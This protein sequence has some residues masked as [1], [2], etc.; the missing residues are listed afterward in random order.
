[1][2]FALLIHGITKI[3]ITAVTQTLFGIDIHTAANLLRKLGREI[4]SH[5]FQ[6]ALYENTA[7]I[8]GDIFPCR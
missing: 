2:E 5:T 6:Y 3:G 7:C 8:I 4:F 1:M